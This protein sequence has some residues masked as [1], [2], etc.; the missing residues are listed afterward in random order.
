MRKLLIID[1]HN[2]LFQMFFGMPSRIVNKDGK[3]IQGTLGFVGAMLKI[4]KMINPTHL[5]I[6]FD[7]EHESIRTKVNPDYKANR[8]IYSTVADEDNPYSQLND[9]YAALEFLRI[10]HIETTEYEADDVISSY[11]IR[12]E[13]EIE[14]VISSFDSDFFQL[15]DDNVSVLRYRGDH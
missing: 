2:L 7:S 3:D 11:A 9:V 6:L 1:G 15:I 13:K 14:I 8:T 4:V 12:Y 5:V 10:K